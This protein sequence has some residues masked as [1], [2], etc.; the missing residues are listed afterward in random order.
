MNRV[1]LQLVLA[2]LLGFVPGCGSRGPSHHVL[3]GGDTRHRQDCP[4]YWVVI[5][6]RVIDRNA[7]SVRAQ[8]RSETRKKHGEWSGFGSP[9]DGFRLKHEGQ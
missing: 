8:G 7:L 1:V 2:C 9:G 3:F 4:A 6:K 5:P